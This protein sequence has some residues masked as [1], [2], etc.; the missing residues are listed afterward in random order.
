MMLLLKKY[1]NTVL[2]ILTVPLILFLLC[3]LLLALLA[4][5]TVSLCEFDFCRLIGRRTAFLP[6]QELSMRNMTRTSSVSAALL[7][8]PSSNL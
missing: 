4:A 5:F 6:L 7:S 2:I 3:R 8:T 1:A